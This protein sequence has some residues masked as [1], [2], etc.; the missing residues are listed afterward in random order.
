MRSVS[1]GRVVRRTGISL[2]TVALAWAST[3]SPAAGQQERL[4]WRSALAGLPL[5][6]AL[7]QAWSAEAWG[8]DAVAPLAFLAARTEKLVLGT[9]IMQICART[10]VS[11]ARRICGLDQ[12]LGMK[13]AAPRL[14]P[15]TARAME[16]QAVIRITGRR[17]CFARMLRRS[18]RPSWPLVSREKF[19]S[20]ST[21]STGSSSRAASA[22]SGSCASR[23]SNPALPSMRASEAVTDRSSSTTRMAQGIYS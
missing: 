14:I 11:T 1:M 19:M 6:R 3:P 8:M 15:S 12:G 22:P 21:R 17:G 13:S 9:G 5:M 10:P 7:D 16:P 20:C 4:S 23:Q 2:C 18:A